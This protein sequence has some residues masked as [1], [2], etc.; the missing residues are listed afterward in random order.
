MLNK[1]LKR[2]LSDLDVRDAHGEPVKVTS[3][4]FRHTL[5]TRMINNEVSQPTVQRLLD[6]SSPA[7]TARYARIKDETLRREWERYDHRAARTLRRRLL[8]VPGRLTHHAGG[9]TLHLPARWPWHD[10]Y[11][12]ALDRIRALPTLA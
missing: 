7:M 9:W 8:A 3:H 12:R 6:H 10:D 2:W 1:R 5:G 4:R 11:T